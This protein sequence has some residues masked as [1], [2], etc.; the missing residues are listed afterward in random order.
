MCRFSIPQGHLPNLLFH[1][2]LLLDLFLSFS[3]TTDD[4]VA[5]R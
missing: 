5:A 3:S 4:H 1:F 2:G